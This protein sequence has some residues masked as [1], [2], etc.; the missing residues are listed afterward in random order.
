MTAAS[1]PQKTQ[2][3]LSEI[4]SAAHSRDVVA[5][6]LEEC[7]DAAIFVNLPLGE[8]GPV[9]GWVGYW[10]TADGQSIGTRPHT[11]V[12]TAPEGEVGRLRTRIRQ[13]YGLPHVTTVLRDGVAA[14]VASTSE[15]APDTPPERVSDVGPFLDRWL[16]LAGQA[17]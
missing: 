11:V 3:L 12:A 5:Y 8:P 4:F 9:Y 6:A 16:E 15:A 7:N 14:V 1:E 17:D 10:H 13:S 2:T